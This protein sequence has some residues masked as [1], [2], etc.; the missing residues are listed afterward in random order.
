MTSSELLELAVESLDMYQRRSKGHGF[1]LTISRSITS[2]QSILIKEMLII[3]AE[4]KASSD[5]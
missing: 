1:P 3:N 2:A 4:E 5:K